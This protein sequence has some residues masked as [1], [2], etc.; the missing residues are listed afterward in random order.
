MVH[1]S[2]IKD[3]YLELRLIRNSLSDI[4]NKLTQQHGIPI[5]IPDLQLLQLSDHLR[6]TYIFVASK[7]MCD[8]ETVSINTGRCRA[9]ESNYLN[10][11]VHM[12][13]LEK[14]RESKTVIFTVKQIQV[15]K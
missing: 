14:N 15:K 13:W 8:A 11:L 9:T 4:E 6:K 1:R 5:T 3:I 10:Q 7:G 12:D 2:V